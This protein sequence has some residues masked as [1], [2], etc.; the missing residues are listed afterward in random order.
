MGA[1]W[2]RMRVAYAL[3]ELQA[4]YVGDGTYGD[5]PQYHADFYNSYVMHPYL[6]M[7]MEAVGEQEPAWKS[8]QPRDPQTCDALRRHPGACHRP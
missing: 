4:W 2:D 1:D 3:N 7:L 8:M 5:G 6:L